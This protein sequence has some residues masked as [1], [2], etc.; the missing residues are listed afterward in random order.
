MS[1]THLHKG[2]QVHQ[3]ALPTVS[4]ISLL[5][6][7][8]YTYLCSRF[9]GLVLYCHGGKHGR[10]TLVLEKELRVQHLDLMFPVRVGHGIFSICQA[11]LVLSIPQIPGCIHISASNKGSTILEDWRSVSSSTQ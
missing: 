6:H 1:T 8:Q 10:E 2:A 5:T 3:E 4:S 7:T 9:S 11:E